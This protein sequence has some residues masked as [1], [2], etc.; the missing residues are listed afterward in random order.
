MKENEKENNEIIEGGNRKRKQHRKKE[1][2][3]NNEINK[4]AKKDR[5]K[6]GKRKEG[7]KIN[8][9]IGS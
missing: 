7:I 8:D 6:Y 2:N 9:V 1:K 3:I 5:T 4:V